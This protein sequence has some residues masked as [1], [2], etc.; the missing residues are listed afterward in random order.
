MQNIRV[1]RYGDPRT[2][3]YWQGYVEPDDLS[4]I[5]FVA[6]DGGVMVFLNRDPETGAV[7]QGT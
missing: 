6:A 5:V 3:E 4:W 2:R 1:H 7:L